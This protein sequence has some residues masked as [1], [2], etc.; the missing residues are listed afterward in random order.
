MYRK[1]VESRGAVVR[2]CLSQPTLP[3]SQ[4]R[5]DKYIPILSIIYIH[6]HSHIKYINEKINPSAMSSLTLWNFLN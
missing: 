6:S 2:A 5:V 3:T 1:C 4:T